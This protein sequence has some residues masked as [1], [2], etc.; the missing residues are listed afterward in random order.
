MSQLTTATQSPVSR[1]LFTNDPPSQEETSIIEEAIVIAETEL[2][3][4]PGARDET[5]A[6]SY[7][8]VIMKRSEALQDFI[9]AH[10]SLLS[11]KRHLPPEL[12][13]LIFEYGIGD[14]YTRG[15]TDIT[16]VTRFAS[17]CRLWRSV[18]L[19]NP[20]LWARLPSFSLMKKKT[21]DHAYIRHIETIME[22]SCEVLLSL[23]VSA[24]FQEVLCH[25]LLDMLVKASKRWGHLILDSTAM[26][27]EGLRVFGL[28][29]CLHTLNLGVDN[30]KPIP[31]T[32]TV[33]REAPALRTVNLRGLWPVTIE[34]PWQQLD[35]YSEDSSRSVGFAHVLRH[36]AQLQQLSYR[37]HF[38]PL[39][40][41]EDL[42][43]TTFTKLTSLKL[44]HSQYEPSFGPLLANLT[45][46]ALEDVRITTFDEQLI[47]QLI[48]MVRRCQLKEL[49]LFTPRQNLER[50]KF[51]QLLHS[52]PFLERL[53]VSDIPADDLEQLSTCHV[54]PHLR[55]LTIHINWHPHPE[56]A[57]ID[58]QR[59]NA[60]AQSRCSPDRSTLQRKDCL[61]LEH[62][63]LVFQQSQYCL[64]THAALEGWGNIGRSP[65]EWA[66]L[67][68]ISKSLEEVSQPR[69]LHLRTRF[70][71]SK[72][73]LNIAQ[74]K[75]AIN[76]LI[77]LSDIDSRV[78]LHSHVICHIQ[79]ALRDIRDTASGV[80]RECIFDSWKLLNQE[81]I[82]R[83]ITEG[84]V[85]KWIRRG[86]VSL[87]Y[88][89]DKQNV[90][91]CLF[92]TEDPVVRA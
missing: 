43:R 50:G 64:G 74:L 29:P 2:T 42:P 15:C 23:H 12:W 11:I 6:F 82:S 26:T 36:S 41:S 39:E 3:V 62:F 59:I 80:D 40:L 30:L 37:T 33:F 89:V 32:V 9:R 8:D 34:L 5:P 18:A 72:P 27:V 28:L 14:H 57:I 91:D 21:R 68:R 67:L 17:V 87:E 66:E 58:D 46:P 92:G 85:L 10:R 44:H 65:N 24:H 73:R 47:D 22:R 90:A 63:S 84:L 49:S 75:T 70:Y 56:P 71:P 54:V 38:V 88:C 55:S 83:A 19:S 77:A 61:R 60:L 69:G 76:E 20:R 86:Q 79:N 1:L 53:D 81:W 48:K 16:Q 25:P 51:S 78:L 35:C 45:L 13:S 4:L 7:S 31:R 52:T